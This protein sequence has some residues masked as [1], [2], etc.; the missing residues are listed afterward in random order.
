MQIIPVWKNG[1]ASNRLR[2]KFPTCLDHVGMALT[3]PTISYQTGAKASVNTGA[4]GTS[5]ASI[6]SNQY[7]QGELASPTIT[8][9]GYAIGTL[10]FGSSVTVDLTSMSTL[11]G[12]ATVSFTKLVYIDVVIPTGSAGGYLRIGNAATNGNKLWFDA[13][14]STADIFPGG[15]AFQQT[16]PA[17]YVVVDASNKNVLITNPHGSL[18]CDYVVRVGGLLV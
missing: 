4:T 12:N 6:V 2:L 14:T 10:P 7:S 18:A 16:N 11:D 15:A 5:T 8:A 3:N 1:Q 9:V 17:S 13:K